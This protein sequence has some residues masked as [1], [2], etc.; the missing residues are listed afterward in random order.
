MTREQVDVAREEGYESL[1]KFLESL[2][3]EAD[4][5]IEPDLKRRR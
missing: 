4:D 5:R 2:D 3:A 1:V